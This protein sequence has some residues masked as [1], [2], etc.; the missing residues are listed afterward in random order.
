MAAVDGV[1]VVV[2]T[3]EHQTGTMT[4]PEAMQV[5]PFEEVVK[6]YSTAYSNGYDYPRSKSCSLSCPCLAFLCVG[7]RLTGDR[8]YPILFLP[9]SSI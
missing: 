3:E 4:I 2:A 6:D 5:A 9:H 8:S 1:T 7:F